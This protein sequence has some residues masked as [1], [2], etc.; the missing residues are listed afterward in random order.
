MERVGDAKTKGD[1]M[2]EVFDKFMV[3]YVKVHLAESTYEGYRHHLVP[4]RKFFGDMRPTSIRPVHAY[5]YMDTRPTVAA[6]R[7]VSVLQSALGFAVRKGVLDRNCLKGQI[8]RKG[9][10]REK[11]RKRV[12][13]L[14]ELESFCSINPHL[15]GWVT[16]KRITGLRQGQMLAINLTEH[17]DGKTLHP[18]TSKGG[19]DTRYSGSG[20]S[21]AIK[22][23]LRDR[24]PVGPLFINRNGNPVTAT[25]F[26]SAWQRAMAK[27]VQIG[28]ERFNEHD[29]R[30][31]TATEA[32]TLIEAMKLLGHTS[33]KVTQAVYRLKPEDVEVK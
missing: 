23:I 9:T 22:N 12:P 27:F 3:E 18:I 28:K 7:E 15:R 5:K 14:E 30:K 31:T 26:R 29:I 33:P 24:L 13:S 16:L 10:A 1:T 11:P 8:E 6:N 4:L 2:N 32:D 25:G 20:L 17:W 21:A 19:R